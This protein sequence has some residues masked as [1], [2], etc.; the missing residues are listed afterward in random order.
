[1]IL[2]AAAAASSSPPIS[3]CALEA[4]IKGGFEVSHPRSLDVAVAVANARRDG[5]LPPA[6]A[7]SPSND[8]LLRLMISDIRRMESRLKDGRSA[9]A[10]DSTAP[11]SLVL[12]GP[13]L[14]SH[15][16]L[17]S[18]GLLT[19]YHVDGPLAGKPVVLTHHVV[20]K[21]LLDGSLAPKEAAEQG[22]LIFAGENTLPVQQVF[23]QGFQSYTKHG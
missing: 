23:R 7:N 17:T 18:G 20:L 1:V 4:T 6:S 3:A 21:A 19:R 10:K 14:W 15:F 2:I 13:G 22:L 12:V 8:V 5:L 9:L 11:F 16:H